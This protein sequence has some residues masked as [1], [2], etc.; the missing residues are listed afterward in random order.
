MNLTDEKMNVSA[1]YLDGITIANMARGGAAQLRANAEEVNALNVF[2]VPDGDT[3]DNMSMTIEGG[4][5]AINGME[6]T[7]ISTVMDTMARGMLLGARGNSGVILSQFFA[8]IAKGLSGCDKADVPTLGAA[9]E[10]GVK[11]AYASVMKPTEGTI[12]TVAREGVAYAVKNITEES[13]VVSLFADLIKEMYASLQRTP[14]LLPALKE[15]EVI[16]SGGAGL[17]YIMDGCNRVLNGEDLVA[18]LP[19]A[20]AT[21]APKLDLTKISFGPDSVMEYGYCTECLLQLQNSKVDIEHFDVNVVKDFLQSVGDSIVAFQTD[22]IV[23]LHVHTMTPEKVLEFCRQYGEFLTIKIENMSVQHTETETDNTA[24]K[25]EKPAKRYG[26]VAV[27]TGDGIEELYRE[28]GT[29]YIIYGG[30]TQNP[31]TQDFLNAFEEVSAEHIFVV[32]N[33]KNIY[34]AASQAAEIYTDA[35]VHVIASNNIGSGYIAIAALDHDEEDVEVA[36]QQ[37]RDAMNGVA[38]G[39]VSPSVRDAELNGVQVFKDDYIAFVDKEM[40]TSRSNKEA[41]AMDLIDTMLSVPDKFMMTV[42]FGKDVTDI[43]KASICAYLEENHPD[44]EAYYVNG[45]QDI[46]PYIFICE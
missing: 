35:D 41:A 8:G 28:L 42:F 4:I 16:D 7:N 34:M 18:D 12:L 3:G 25:K 36:A 39:Y 13:T 15:A 5:S 37:M 22:S 44:A 2:P 45:G 19:T 6:E 10:E 11:K 26:I 38:A 27:C 46:Y 31:S 1:K 21:A 33:N 29:D 20:V 14:E 17:F 43:E 24:K 9:L 23:K 32:P 30:Q 40:V